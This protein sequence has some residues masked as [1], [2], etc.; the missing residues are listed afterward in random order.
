MHDNHGVLTKNYF[1]SD[2]TTFDFIGEL[3][4]MEEFILLVTRLYDGDSV[5]RAF[6]AMDIHQISRY[7]DSERFQACVASLE[8]AEPDFTNDRT[9]LPG[10]RI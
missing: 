6:A 9:A 2:E 10:C 3:P 8:H 5:A 7:W 1:V 4:P